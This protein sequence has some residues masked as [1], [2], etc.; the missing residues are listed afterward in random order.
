MKDTIK[1]KKIR[2]KEN[3]KTWMISEK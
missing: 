3:D 2:K 1:V